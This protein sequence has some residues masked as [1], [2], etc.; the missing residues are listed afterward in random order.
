[1]CI[2]PSYAMRPLLCACV[3]VQPDL[4]A[5][6]V[7]SKPKST[8][9]AQNG[10][11]SLLLET[12]AGILS[13][14]TF[15]PDSPPSTRSKRALEELGLRLHH[16][17]AEQASSRPGP[18]VGTRGAHRPIGEPGPRPQPP[19]NSERGPISLEVVSCGASRCWKRGGG[20]R[21]SNSEENKIKFQRTFF[22]SRRERRGQYLV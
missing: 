6:S 4:R 14:F 9:H 5:G 2:C 19:R 7:S 3:R 8:K 22:P 21:F 10:A 15:C 12:A 20:C 18:H 13:G 17:P 16:E 11:R 1:M